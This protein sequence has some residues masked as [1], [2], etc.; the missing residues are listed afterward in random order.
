VG[1][2]T[3]P[4]HQDTYLAADVAADLGELAGELVA[5]EAVAGQPALV[6]ALDGADLAGL[7]TVGVAGDLDGRL[8]GGAAAAV[9]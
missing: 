1:D 6:E 5:D 8:L 3:P 4:V 9:G 2:V 7:E